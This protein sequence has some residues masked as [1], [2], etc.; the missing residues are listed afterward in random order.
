[1]IKKKKKFANKQTVTTGLFHIISFQFVGGT[2]SG[3]L[4]KTHPGCVV[5]MCMCK[6]RPCG[7]C[8]L[9]SKHIKMGGER[10][11]RCAAGLGLI[12]GL[13]RRTVIQEKQAATVDPT[14]GQSRP[15]EFSSCGDS[16]MPASPSCAEYAPNTVA[17]F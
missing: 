12:S 8:K 10:R 17:N 15:E 7:V 13:R 2:K 11:S 1:M 3:C 6:P 16:S 4:H 5:K 9:H 14:P